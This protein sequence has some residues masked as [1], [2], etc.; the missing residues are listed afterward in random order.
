MAIKLDSKLVEL[1]KESKKVRV[2]F[3]A[4]TLL[5]FSLKHF[6]PKLT[7]TVYKVKA[8]LKIENDN[9][10][11]IYTESKLSSIDFESELPIAD[12]IYKTTD[13][14]YF[15]VIDGN[16]N[17]NFQLKDSEKLPKWVN[18]AKIQLRYIKVFFEECIFKEEQ[19]IEVHKMVIYGHE[20]DLTQ[21]QY[22]QIKDRTVMVSN[23]CVGNLTKMFEE[24]LANCTAKEREFIN[25]NAED[26]KALYFKKPLCE[27]VA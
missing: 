8:P 19:M 9:A 6:N 4:S 1:T 13:E 25:N 16:I 27:L 14:F 23:E 20:Y 5:I 11:F 2:K 12:G 21:E 3:N 22:D 18:G 15:Q 17:Q 26:Y 24:K 7:D 10:S